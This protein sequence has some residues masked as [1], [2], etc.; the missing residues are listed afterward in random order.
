MI[1]KRIYLK[2]TSVYE[3]FDV[4]IPLGDFNKYRIKKYIDSRAKFQAFTNNFKDSEINMLMFNY[5]KNKLTQSGKEYILLYKPG[6]KREE[7]GN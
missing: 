3:R 6:F 4:F 7:N 1:D 5:I 2:C